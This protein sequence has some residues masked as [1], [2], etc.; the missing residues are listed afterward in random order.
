MI[1]KSRKKTGDPAT[2]VLTNE[3]DGHGRFQKECEPQI[4]V[5]HDRF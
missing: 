4:M 2:I 1:S 3:I 5:I